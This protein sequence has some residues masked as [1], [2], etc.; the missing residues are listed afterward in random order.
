MKAYIIVAAVLLGAF[1][2]VH[3]ARNFCPFSYVASGLRQSAKTGISVSSAPAAAMPPAPKA[4][5]RRVSARP[6]GRLPLLENVLKHLDDNDP[7]L[8]TAFNDLTADEKALFRKRYFAEKPEHLNE[9][10]T[11]VYVLG[12]NLRAQKDWQFMRTV[13]AEKP[14]LSLADCSK[15]QE[16]TGGHEDMGIEVTLSYPAMMALSVAA[17]NAGRDRTS[18]LSV[19]TAAKKSSAIVVRE[20]AVLLEDRLTR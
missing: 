2:A 17:E 19:L 12:R 18:A 11:I 9:R 6:A 20:K 7:R 3:S 8:D 1:F 13:A 10:G 16:L 5:A 15:P 4:E 14:C